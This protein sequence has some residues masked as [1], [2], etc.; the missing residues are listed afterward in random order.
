[1][2]SNDF[3][4]LSA[5]QPAEAAVTAEVRFNADHAIFQGHFPGQPVVPGVCM[6]QLI[7][8]ITEQQTGKALF[9]QEA[10]LCKFLSVIDPLKTPKVTA[11]LQYTND[12][13][14]YQVNATLSEGETT[15]LKLKAV[16]VPEN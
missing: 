14:R 3:F 11:Q 5:V 9:M 13:A 7:K 6:L 15:F 16:F 10:P 2:L 12:G 1:M 8:E 4:F